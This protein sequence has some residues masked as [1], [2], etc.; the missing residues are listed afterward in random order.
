MDSYLAEE[1]SENIARG[2]SPDESRRQ[3]HLKFG[4]PQQVREGLW[5]QNTL[6]VIDNV[7]R[8]LKYA[9][10]TLRRSPGFTFVAVL[11]MAMGIGANVALFTVV[12]SVLLNPLPF[13]EPTRLIRLYEHSTDD[14]FPYNMVAGGIFAAWKDQ[15]HSFSDLAI[16]SNSEEYNLSGAGGQLPEKVR[17]ATSSWNLFSTLGVEPVLGRGF[18]AVDDQPSANATVVLSWGLWKRRFGGDPLILN[19]TIR[20]NAKNYTVIGIMPSW[21]AYP[22]QSIQLWTP[23]Y[24]LSMRCNLWM[25]ITSWQSGV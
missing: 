19:Q 10:R 14:K 3:A 4:S 2:M 18:N 25:A 16:L 13:K 12:R 5:E 20:L 21:F 11:V 1:I 15:S 22:A 8:N 7:G 17:A 6:T 23:I 24:H 9:A